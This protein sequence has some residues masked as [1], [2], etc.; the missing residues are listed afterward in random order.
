MY[1]ILNRHGLRTAVGASC[2]EKPIKALLSFSGFFALAAA[3]QILAQIKSNPAVPLVSGIIRTLA[4]LIRDGPFLGH[5]VASLSILFAGVG[6]ATVVGFTIGIFLYRY[7]YFKAAAY[8]VIDCLRNV[9]SL[10]LFP[11]LIVLLGLGPPAQIFVI[12][13]TAWSAVVLS[14][15]NSLDVDKN[16]VEAARSFGAG[17][18]RIIFGIRVP[19]AARGIITGIRIGVG[20]GWI[21]LI[22]AEML[23]AQRGLGFFLLWSSQTFQF[24]RVYAS[25]IVIA[26]IGGIVNYALLLVQKA[27]TQ[28]TGEKL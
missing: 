18:W 4:N 13:W 28:I 6:I 14:T 25:I 15:L 5:I 23:G 3:W 26:T 12:F 24:E 27:L 20:N 2:F 22:A 19:M 7:K 10:T 21:S 8:P 17:E 16:I 1:T 9:A 11:L